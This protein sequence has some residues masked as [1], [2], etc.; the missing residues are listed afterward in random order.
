L[1]K[2]LIRQRLDPG[3]MNA[4]YLGI[5]RLNLNRCRR[6]HFPEPRDGDLK[7]RRITCV[8]AVR[9]PGIYNDAHQKFFP[10]RKMLEPTD[11]P[12]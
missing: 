1:E 3:A 10:K 11:P 7:H 4:K 12:A 9:L 6:P 2:V 8:V 5:V